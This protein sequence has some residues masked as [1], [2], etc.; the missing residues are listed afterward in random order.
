MTD[1]W[2][3]ININAS[4]AEQELLSSE[5]EICTGM[6]TAAQY[7]MNQYVFAAGSALSVVS[8]TTPIT[9]YF[10]FLKLQDY[11]TVQSV[12]L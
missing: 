12:H 6:K 4:R 10:S 7:L 3:S 5:A 11:E 1:E 2:F 8:T 9:F